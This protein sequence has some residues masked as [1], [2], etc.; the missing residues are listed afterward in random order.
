MKK[1]TSTAFISLVAAAVVALFCVL[2]PER[3]FPAAQQSD[4]GAAAECR[5]IKTELEGYR[6][7][8]NAYQYVDHA[9][10]LWGRFLEKYPTSAEAAE[11]HLALGLMYA[12]TNRHESAITHLEAYLRTA[13]DSEDRSKAMVTLAGSYLSLE[14][15]DEAEKLLKALSVPSTGRDHRIGQMANQLLAR[16]GSLRKLKIGLPALPFSAK[17]SDGRAVKLDD[18]RGKVVLLDFWASWCVPCRKEMPN[19][20]RLYEQ[21]HERGFEI[22]G[23]SLDDKE[24]NFKGY[25]E[26]EKIPWPQIFDGKGWNSEIGQ[27]YA[28]SAI[29]ATYILD[30]DGIIRFKNVRGTELEQAVMGLVEKK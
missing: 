3:A 20:K 8:M 1:K 4:S 16:I 27:L 6:R 9:E 2:T 14:R 30:R 7:T 11:A 19:V 13:G 12:Q 18:Y 23:V 5:S 10:R 26:S 25:L 24:L 17:T 15:Y 21:Y 28:V 29:P 22:I